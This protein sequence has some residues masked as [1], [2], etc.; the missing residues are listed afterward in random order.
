[1]ASL[2]EKIVETL[3]SSRGWRFRDLHEIRSLILSHDRPFTVDSIEA[4]LM[5][6]DLRD[7]G[8]KSLP[9]PSSLNKISNL[10]GPLVLQVVSTR[11]IYQSSIE[12]SFKNS[13]RRLLR[14]ILTDG[15]SE[16]TA[17]E[18][19]E[20]L[21]ITQ[22]IV[23]GTKA[24]LEN[25]VPIHSGILCLGPK[26]FT[27]MGG[28]VETL[29]EEWQM[30][31]KYSGLSRTA[32]KLSPND[33]GEG[34]PPFEKLHAESNRQNKIQQ[35]HDSSFAKG[36]SSRG[37]Q[38]AD[39]KNNSKDV[40]TDNIPA[41]SKKDPLTSGTEG[42]NNDASTR[43]K[44]AIEVVPVQNQAAAQKLLQ[45]MQ[46]PNEGRYGR[47]GRHRGRGRDREE[48]HPVFTLEEWEKRNSRNAP[49]TSRDEEMARQLQQQ[50][51]LEDNEGI[52]AGSSEA[53]Q[54]RNRG[55]V[56]HYSCSNGDTWSSEL[57]IIS[58]SQ[59]RLITTFK[60]VKKGT[61]GGVTISGLAA[62][63]AA[64]CAIGLAFVGV[65]FVTTN[66]EARVARRQMLMIPL[67]TFS[68]LLGSLI[69]SFLGATLQYSGYCSMRKKV[70]G[71][72]G[73]MVV[74]ISGREILDNNGVNVVSILLTTI[75]TGILC[76]YIF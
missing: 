39:G 55:I 63:A 31:Q 43:P 2:E 12:A 8:G 22:E 58:N 40:A 52:G 15:Y 54:L 71:K 17:I 6:M 75:L 48:E 60:K 70:V 9:D 27:I 53:E 76:T 36:E 51:D 72:A 10:Q 5:A 23:P 3:T 67:A 24:R 61:N 74:K 46:E 49:D 66:C 62:A 11:D 14:F 59:P 16:I 20:I 69:D 56:G 73:P 1:M 21:S 47:G 25:K 7:F 29:F 64:G 33:D 26:T 45:K 37:R 50:M 4:D 42:R 44:E 41:V 30:S 65:G 35:S 34:P 18:Y 38:V 57:G 68:G 32:V 13:N 19:S 28:I